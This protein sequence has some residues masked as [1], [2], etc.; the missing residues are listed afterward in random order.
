MTQLSGQ[1]HTYGAR[2]VCQQ[3]AVSTTEEC[4]EPTDH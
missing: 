3:S 2:A 4:A 1:R